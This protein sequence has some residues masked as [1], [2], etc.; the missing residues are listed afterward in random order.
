[1]AWLEFRE[2]TEGCEEAQKAGR[3]MTLSILD[4]PPK[5]WEY[6]TRSP[7]LQGSSTPKMPS[8]WS[9]S[10]QGALSVTPPDSTTAQ[11][12]PQPSAPPTHTHAMSLLPHSISRHHQVSLDTFL[13]KPRVDILP[14]VLTAW[15]VCQVHYVIFLSDSEPLKNVSDSLLPLLTHASFSPASCISLYTSFFLL[16]IFSGLF[17]THVLSG[18]Q[19][20][21]TSAILG[22]A[23]Q[24]GDWKK[25]HV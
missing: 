16:Q 19:S 21:F 3:E 24:T 15:T 18:N 25:V 2:S 13:A 14:T 8:L 7:G 5:Q 12:T 22:C 6:G 10:K 20:E 23:V 1:M 9:I 11:K 4:F 17:C